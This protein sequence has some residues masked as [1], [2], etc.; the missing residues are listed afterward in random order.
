M[1]YVQRKMHGT[2]YTI[3]HNFPSEMID[4]I[5]P[6]YNYGPYYLMHGD[7]LPSNILVDSDKNIVAIIDW[8]WCS[9]VPAQLLV[10]PACITGYDI[11]QVGCGYGIIAL[12]AGIGAMQLE[13][14][15]ELREIT[16][17][18][19][20]HPFSKLWIKSLKMGSF[21]VAHALFYVQIN[22]LLFMRPA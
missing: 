5:R 20:S 17:N 7:L 12:S 15:G 18:P 4:W 10:P 9:V 14:T 19:Y 1:P 3:L 13:M 6:Q 22:V 2:V 8:E 21:W 11:T 16:R